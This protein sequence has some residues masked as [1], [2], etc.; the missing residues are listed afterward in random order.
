MQGTLQTLFHRYLTFVYRTTRWEWL[1]LESLEADIARG[2]PR[3][4]CVWHE[5]LTLSTYLRDWT[6]HR[7]VILASRHAD[8]RLATANMQRRGLDIIEL[9]T[10]GENRAALKDAVRAVRAGASVGIAVDGPLGPAHVAKPGAVVLGALARVQVSPVTYAISRKL[11]LRNWDR[12]IIPLP[13]G[14]GVLAVGDGFS[15][16]PRLTPEET[17]AACTRL[18]GL[19]DALTEAAE[20]RLAE[21]RRRRR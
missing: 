12:H 7:L 2:V 4:L 19:I 9:A 15:P 5:R 14:R 1:G 6:D 3:V 11:R 18:A 17:E 13:F 8:A 16:P 10:S 21:R 20:A